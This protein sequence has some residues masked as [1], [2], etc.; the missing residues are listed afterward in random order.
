MYL[1]LTTTYVKPHDKFSSIYARPK[2]DYPQ[3]T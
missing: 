1:T 3:K 2:S